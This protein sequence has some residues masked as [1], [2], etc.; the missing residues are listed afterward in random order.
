MVLYS[1]SRPFFANADTYQVTHTRNL[2]DTLYTPTAHR[3]TFVGTQLLF[4]NHLLTVFFIP[5]CH[6]LADRQIRY[7]LLATASAAATLGK[8]PTN[9]L[10]KKNKTKKHRSPLEVFRWVRS[11]IK[12]FLDDSR[13]APSCS[14]C[15]KRVSIVHVKCHIEV[16]KE[17]QPGRSSLQR[18]TPTD[19]TR[20]VNSK[21]HSSMTAKTSVS[22]P[23]ASRPVQLKCSNFSICPLCCYLRL[24]SIVPFVYSCTIAT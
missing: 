19:T 6:K 7:A 13:Q 18:S 12:P 15:L 23:L 11:K 20:F 9:M 3:F 2:M 24:I 10:A 17:A 1:Y 16:L 5:S 21:R 14:K 8:Q 22:A 4:E